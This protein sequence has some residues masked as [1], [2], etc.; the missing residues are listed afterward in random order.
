VIAGCAHAGIINIVRHARKMI[1]EK[2]H[3]V[4]GGFHLIN[5][6][7]E[8]IER[9][10]ADM[11]AIEPDYIVPAHCTGFEAASLFAKEMPEQFI[12]NTTGASYIFE[13]VRLYGNYG[14]KTSQ[15]K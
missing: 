2:V 5:A 11:K 12:I 3:V 9:T 7:P 13:R 10:L 4:I 6:A 1:G 15:A 8:I 14:F